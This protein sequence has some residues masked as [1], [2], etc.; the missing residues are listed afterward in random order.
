MHVKSVVGSQNLVQGFQACETE[1][2]AFLPTKTGKSRTG[3]TC[4]SVRFEQTE[5]E[6]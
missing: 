4:Q 1:K 6:K 5:F 2:M 3:F